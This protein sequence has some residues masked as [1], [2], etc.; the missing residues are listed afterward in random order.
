MPTFSQAPSAHPRLTIGSYHRPNKLVEIEFSELRYLCPPPP[1]PPKAA[2]GT[3]IGTAIAWLSTAVV[4][5]S[6]V[7][8][9]VAF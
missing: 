6:V 8:M 5:A 3:R 9:A 2:R 4:I 7:A 1:P